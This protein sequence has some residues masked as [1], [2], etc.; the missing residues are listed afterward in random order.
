VSI[1]ADIFLGI[2]A[3]ATLSTAIVQI[4]LLVAAARV[5]KQVSRVVENVEREM[6]PIF[7][8]LNAIAKDA[9]KAAAVATLQVERVDSL[10]A[11]VIRRLEHVL[12]AFQASLSVPARESRAVVS[13]L[14][15]TFQA[16]RNGRSGGRRRR[17]SADDEDALFI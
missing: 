13:A 12:D 5:A 2:I 14:R 8:H 16:L 3:V 1:W 10:V 9:S 6:V 15:A 11:D 4:G 17:S 7:G